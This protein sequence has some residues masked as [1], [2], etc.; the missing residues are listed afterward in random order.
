MIE[1][2]KIIKLKQIFDERGKVMHM[3]RNDSEYFSKFGEI[4]FSV[5][6]PGVVKAWHLHKEMTLNYAVVSGAIKFVFF[7]DRQNS[8]TKGEIEEIFISPENYS[9]IHVPPGI[10]NG[11]KSVGKDLSIL[12]NCS[13]IPHDPSEI[14]RKPYNDTKIPYEWDIKYK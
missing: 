3:L 1:G 10:W 6:Y 12:A 4:Y 14:I 7:D 5:T 2:L 8:Q 9:L 13:T 11:F